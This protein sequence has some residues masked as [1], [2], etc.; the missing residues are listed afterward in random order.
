MCSLPSAGTSF[1]DLAETLQSI[2]LHSWYVRT[3][4]MVCFC[5][6]TFCA[7]M[8]SFYFSKLLFLHKS[9]AYFVHCI[10]TCSAI[11]YVKLTCCTYLW[12]CS[13]VLHCITLFCMTLDRVAIYCILLYFVFNIGFTT[14]LSLRE[15]K[16]KMKMKI[17]ILRI[18]TFHEINS[19]F[20]EDIRNNVFEE[21]FWLQL[22]RSST[23]FSIHTKNMVPFF[24]RFYLIS[25]PS[26]H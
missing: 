24:I 14:F 26:F 19:I 2:P 15:I 18:A 1:A 17:A 13:A 12:T 7:L 21:I 8:W 4:C 3:L 25:L 20:Y 11:L 10:V 23:T 9:D 22:T 6:R 5:V 16:M